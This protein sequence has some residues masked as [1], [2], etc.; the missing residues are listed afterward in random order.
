MHVKEIVA[1][2]TSKR[3]RRSEETREGASWAQMA[4]QITWLRNASS[5]SQQHTK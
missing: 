1:K 3:M 5:C 4:N 2:E